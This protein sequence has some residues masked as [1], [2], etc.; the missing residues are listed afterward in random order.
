[1][2]QEQTPKDKHRAGF[3]KFISFEQTLIGTLF[4]ADCRLK[5]ET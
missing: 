1:M 2:L 4:C 5:T 3:Q